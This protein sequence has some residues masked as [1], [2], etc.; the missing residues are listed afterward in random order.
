MI[1]KILA[2]ALCILL[3]IPQTG[4]WDYVEYNDLA[5]IIAIGIDFDK[6][7]ENI[8]FTLQFIPTSKPGRGSGSEEQS[9]NKG[10]VHSA[11]DTT[12]F[13]ALSKLQQVVDKNFFYGY[14]KI[15]IIGEDAAKNILLP[16]MEVHDR[17]P[18]IR[19]STNVIFTP[20]KA[21]NVLS[22][23]DSSH[24]EISGNT[25]SNLLD[26]ASSNGA[27]FSV[28]IQKFLEMLSI[29]G[30]EAVGPCTTTTI[31]EPD[32]KGGITENVKANEQKEGK[33]TVSG[34]AA[35]KGGS[36]A[37]WLDQKQSL[38]FGWITGKKINAYKYTGSVGET[39]RDEA[40]FRVTN[41]KSKIK[42]KLINGTVSIDINVKVT[43]SLRKYYAFGNTDFLDNKDIKQL[44]D[45]LSK[46]ITSDIEAALKKGQK[47]L[48]SDIFGFGFELFRKYPKL[49]NQK[50]E[51]EWNEIF[52]EVPVNIKVD[53]KI[54]NTG[55][56]I[57]SLDV[58]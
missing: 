52:P 20:G 31:K 4:C 18:S 53:A 12:L 34:L 47:E 46:S 30:L 7:T 28:T 42:V 25:L 19:S 11:A 3:L 36:L 6:Q 58:K 39:K 55:T 33:L 22:T 44:E 26:T 32:I 49:W 45:K 40:Y 13:G 43:S 21:E 38:G 23:I 50:Y 10:L 24:S 54:I 17:A 51:K 15:L 41:S 27:S 37:G 1:R 29:S 5:Q 35:F 14:S 57:R 56:N 9:K 16:M 8:V 2:L 48:Q